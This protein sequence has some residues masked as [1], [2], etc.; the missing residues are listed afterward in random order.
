MSEVK[1][2]SVNIDDEQYAALKK[3]AETN[4]CTVAD[5]LGAYV[6]DLTQVHSNGSDER[7]F[8]RSYFERTHL[9]TGWM[10]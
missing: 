4:D 3:I 2:L 5:I 9:Y 8:A 1:R 7:E 6:A 10:R